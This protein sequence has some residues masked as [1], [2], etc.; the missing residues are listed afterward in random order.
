MDG[1]SKSEEQDWSQGKSLYG[2]RW[3]TFAGNAGIM[4]FFGNNDLTTAEYISKCLGKTQVET[5]RSGEVAQDQRNKGLLGQSEVTEL[6]DLLTP[7]EIRRQ[8]SRDDRLKR[9][10][11]LW[12]GHHPIMAQRCIWYDLVNK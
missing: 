3:E 9:Q 1:K 11:I 8:F 10:L 5:T 4:Q 12:A 7:D 6:Y 2:D